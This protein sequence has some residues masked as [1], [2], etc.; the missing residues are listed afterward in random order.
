MMRPTA[1]SRGSFAARRPAPPT[2]TRAAR[3]AAATA[4]ASGAAAATADIDIR[5]ELAISLKDAVLGARR[6][7]DLSALQPCLACGGGGAAGGAAAPRCAMCLGRGAIERSEP[8]RGGALRTVL[9]QCPAC[10]GAGARVPQERRCSACAGA[11]RA[12]R[13]R[14]LAVVVPPGAAAGEILRVAGGGHAARAP[15]APAGDALFALRVRREPNLERA[16][17]NLLS[18]VEVPYYTALLGGAVEVLTVGGAAAAL[19]VPPGTQHGAAL[20]LRGAGVGAGAAAGDHIFTVAVTLP[21]AG[22]AG[23][24]EAALLRRLAAVRRGE[25]ARGAAEPP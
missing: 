15:G 10:V 25:A 18:S 11:G 2:S 12:L 13:P 1:P 22:A 16:G 14:R 19:A 8:T 20:R 24:E 21:A 4:A 3:A 7:V 23:E 5:A 17:R 6:E 9:A